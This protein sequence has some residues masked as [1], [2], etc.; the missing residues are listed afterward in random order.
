METPPALFAFFWKVPF[1]NW[2]IQIAGAAESFVVIPGGLNLLPCMCVL[3]RTTN[4]LIL[5]QIFQQARSQPM[6]IQNRKMCAHLLSYFNSFRKMDI[7]VSTS[8]DKQSWLLQFKF[9][10]WFPDELFHNFRASRS[11]DRRVLC[12]SGTSCDGFWSSEIVK[13]FVGFV[14]K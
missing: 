2:W 3:L 14:P 7:F 9:G 13:G 1:K 12:Y 8:Q 10:Y 6:A 11:G 5:R 4:C